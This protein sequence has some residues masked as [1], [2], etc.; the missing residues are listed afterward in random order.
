MEISFLRG[1]MGTTA[2]NS[3]VMFGAVVDGLNVKCEI[4]KEA[5][6]KHFGSRSD[7]EFDLLKAF[8]KGRVRIEEVARTRLT[9]NSTRR[10]LMM[11]SHF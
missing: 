2:M 1:N 6:K 8:E 11:S 4:S 9:A 5:L 3:S 7:N 10:C